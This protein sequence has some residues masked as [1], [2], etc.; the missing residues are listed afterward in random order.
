MVVSTIGDDDDDDDVRDTRGPAQRPDTSGEW[1]DGRGAAARH[2]SR[3]NGR[4]ILWHAHFAHG[5]CMMMT[6]DVLMRMVM[7]MRT[8]VVKVGGH[9][10]D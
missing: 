8:M 6:T 3:A 2:E 5:D 1:S 9:D 7:A 4:A 10:G